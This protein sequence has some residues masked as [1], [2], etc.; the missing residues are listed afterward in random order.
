MKKKISLL[1]R[2][3]IKLADK[4]AYRLCQEAQIDPNFLS[5]AIN[6]IV[7]VPENDPRIL[8]LANLLNF[9]TDKIFE[10]ANQSIVSG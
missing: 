7:S 10:K 3:R 2:A 1:F 8:R 5:K 9:S 4:P 6:G